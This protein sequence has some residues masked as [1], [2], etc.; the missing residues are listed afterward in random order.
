MK[1]V[2]A[3]QWTLDNCPH[4]LP[5]D[6]VV[7]YVYNKSNLKIQSLYLLQMYIVLV[8][9]IMN[10]AKDI[11]NLGLFEKGILYSRKFSFKVSI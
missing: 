1:K 7:M 6:T 5:N 11:L 3:V 8:S 10:C 2:P 4:R 9:Y